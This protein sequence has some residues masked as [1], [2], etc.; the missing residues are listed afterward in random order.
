MTPSRLRR[1]AC[2]LALAGA[3]ALVALPA[4]ESSEAS[5]SLRVQPEVAE[6]GGR[7]RLEYVLAAGDNLDIVVLRHGEVSRSVIIRP[8]GYISLPLLDDVRAAGFTVRELD[9]RLTALLSDRLKAPEVTVVATT[10][11]EPQVFVY[12]EVISPRVVSLREA[13]TVAQAVATAGGF[14]SSADT[15]SVILMRVH[16]DGRLVASKIEL[17]LSGQPAP[18]M[19]AHNIPLRA[20]DMIFVPKTGIA[21]VNE[22]ITNFVSQPLQGVNSAVSTYANLK[23]IESLNDDT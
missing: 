16:E 20:D 5:G 19:Q 9:V 4:C 1:F 2:S 7:Y 22:W 14:D 13:N 10:T 6:A 11:R 21:Q 17:A 3:S 18:Y 15:D 8:D 12:G 23:I